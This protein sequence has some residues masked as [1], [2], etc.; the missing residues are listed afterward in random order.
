MVEHT[1]QQAGR[2]KRE[3]QKAVLCRS[4]VDGT[5]SRREFSSRT[6]PGAATDS[7]GG[8]DNNWLDGS[9]A[10]KQCTLAAEHAAVNRCPIAFLPKADSLCSHAGYISPLCRRLQLFSAQPSERHT[11]HNPQLFACFGLGSNIQNPTRGRRR[12]AVVA[13]HIYGGIC[14]CFTPT[15]LI[16]E[17]A[18]MPLFENRSLPAAE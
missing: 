6:P 5:K 1:A 4:G 16:P 7:H 15:S 13:V 17:H 18:C 11:L 12:Q 8:F 10:C 14:H 9:M 3:A 2:R